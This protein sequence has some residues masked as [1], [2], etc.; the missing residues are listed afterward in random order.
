MQNLSFF[1]SFFLELNFSF[2]RHFVYL[3]LSHISYPE[4]LPLFA[5][6]AILNKSPSSLEILVPWSAVCQGL[7][8][9][10]PRR[11]WGRGWR[12]GSL[13]TARRADMWKTN[14]QEIKLIQLMYLKI[15]LFIKPQHLSS[16]QILFGKPLSYTSLLSD[17]GRPVSY[18][19]LMQKIKGSFYRPV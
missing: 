2:F 1:F 5:V 18:T 13:V 8:Y 14:K 15:Y 4:L 3:H 17:S 6:A 11:P 12:G 10:K 19:S 9:W 16:Y 7:P